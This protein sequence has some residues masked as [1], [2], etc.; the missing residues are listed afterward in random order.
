MGV[1]FLRVIDGPH[2]HS[3]GRA[4]ADPGVVGRQVD[5]NGSGSCV[6]KNRGQRCAGGF[7]FGKKVGRQASPVPRVTEPQAD[8]KAASPAPEAAPST[9][10]AMREAPERARKRERKS[11]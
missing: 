4:R 11:K 5:R 1:L 9:L 3:V 7:G 2:S 6:S 8:G 10:D